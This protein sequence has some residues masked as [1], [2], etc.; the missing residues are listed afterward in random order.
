MELTTEIGTSNF[1]IL[2]FPLQG[3]RTKSKRQEKRENSEE[4]RE[5]KKKTPMGLQDIR[6]AKCKLKFVYN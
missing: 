4:E 2:I 5:K 3:E 6:L 1:M